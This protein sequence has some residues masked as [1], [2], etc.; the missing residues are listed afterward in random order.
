MKTVGDVFKVLGG[1]TPSTKISEYWQGEYPWATSA[2]L[3]DD[4]HVAA[5]KAISDSAIRDSA[6]SLVPAGSIIVATRVGL[7]RVGIAER[8]MCFSQDCHG[9]ILDPALCDS[10]F[11]ALQLKL[12]VQHFK[13]I[14]RGTTISG[15]TKRQLLETPFKL[16]S[17]EEQQNIVSEIDKQFTRLDAG[18]AALKRVQ[19]NLKRYRGAVLQAATEGKLLG[20]YDA[21]DDASPLEVGSASDLL[22]LILYERKTKLPGV[23]PYKGPQPSDLNLPELPGNWAWATIGQVLSDKTTNGISIKGQD[24]PPGLPALKLDSMTNSGFDYNRVRYLPLDPESVRTK[25]VQRGDFFVSR[26]NGSLRL[27]GRGT[28]AQEPPFPVIFPDTM[29]RLRLNSR[30]VKTGWIGQIWQSRL[31]RR[32]IESKV[33]TTAGIYKISQPEIESVVFPM[34]PISEQFRICR[35]LDRLSTIAE[36]LESTVALALLRA[37]SLRQA[38]LQKAF[39]GELVS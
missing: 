13:L 17:L 36:R 35:E 29:I 24:Q 37:R 23:G 7:G 30:L 32:Q 22:S 10:R 4:L 2:D 9:L 19:A 6:A 11:A 16:P 12:N 5:R 31:I 25:L 26:G 18:I 33:K 15:V 39:S 21:V 34:P 3:G 27:V 8:A 14:S 20:L 28:V 38:I 1:G